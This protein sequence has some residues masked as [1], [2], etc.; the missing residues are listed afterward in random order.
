MAGGGATLGRIRGVGSPLHAV[1]H[2]SDQAL[3][4]LLAADTATGWRAFI[5]GYTPLLLTLIQRAGVNDRD[6]VMDIYVRVCET[7]A[8][9]DCARLRKH[10]PAKGAIGAWLAVVV[11]H[12]IV[13]WVRSRAGRR[14][15]F[16]VIRRLSRADQRVFELYYWDDRTPAEIVEVLRMT[17]GDATTLVDVLDAL[18]RIESVLTERH[19]AD[20]L[21]MAARGRAMLSLEHEMETGAD[22]P[23]EQPGPDR[24]AAAREATEQ[25]ETALASLSPEDAAIVRLKYVQGLS[26]RDIRRALHLERLT[27]DR[28]GDI[29]T[30]LRRALAAP[31]GGGTLALERGER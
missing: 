31:V 19:R 24:Q 13:D 23:D 12:A 5:D 1:A 8:A 16:G 3:R 29:V 21:S 9:N 6:E 25:F 17:D 30:R 28:V 11:R 14:R 2:L 18:D 27:D 22:V 4:T 15:L 7:L 10:D 20:L 26:H